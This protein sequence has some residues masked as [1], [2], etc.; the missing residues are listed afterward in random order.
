[1]NK[2]KHIVSD[3]VITLSIEDWEYEYWCWHALP[4]GWIIIN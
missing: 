3:G 4:F 2:R 1:M